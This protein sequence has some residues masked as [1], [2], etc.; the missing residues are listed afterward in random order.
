MKKTTVYYNDLPNSVSRIDG[1]LI[2]DED[3]WVI[4]RTE[5]KIIQIPMK[6]VIRIES[7]K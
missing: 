4:L 6:L 7:E 5:N 3:D 1:E 2:R